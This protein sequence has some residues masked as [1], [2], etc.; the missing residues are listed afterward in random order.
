MPTTSVIPGVTVR[1]VFEPAPVLP[2]ATGILAVVGVTDRGPVDPTPVGSFTE[3]VDTF[4]PASRFTMPELRAAFA[5]G[6][7]RAVVARTAPGRGGKARLTLLDDEGEEVVRLEAR[8]EGA[9]G[10]R[11]RIR[12]VQVRTLSGAGVKYVNLEISV[13]GE[14]VETIENLVMDASSDHYLFDR[15][16]ASSR[17]LVAVDPRMET[18]LPS[19][20][21]STVLDTSGARAAFATLKRG[22]AG[23]ATATAKRRGRGGNRL[24]LRISDGR[25]SLALLD[26]SGGTAAIVRSRAAGAPGTEIRV[27]VEAVNP[28]TVHLIVTP[29]GGA[30]RTTADV[31]SVQELVD[32]LAN[33]PDIVAEGVGNDL[34]VALAATLLRR[35]VDATVFTEGADPRTYDNLAT[36][37]DLA[38]VSDPAVAFAKVGTAT[39]LPD[40]GDG[41]PLSGGRDEGPALTVADDDGDPVVELRALGGVT[42]ALAVQVTHAVSSLDNTTPVATL[43]I[44]ADGQQ[45]EVFSDLTMDPDDERYLPLVLGDSALLR[46]TDLFVPSRTTSTPA[47]VARRTPLAGGASPSADDYQDALDRLETAEEPDLLIASVARQLDDA[48]V[49]EVHQQVVAHCTKMSEVARNRIGIG[50]VTAAEQAAGV[51]AVLDHADD[52][53]SDHFALCTPAGSEGAFAGLLAHL[54]YFDS[55]T[56]K[57]VPALGVEPGHFTDAQLES[58]ISGNVVAIT[59]RRGL[60]I[61]VAK[62]LLTSGR[63]VNVQRTANKAVRDVKAVA[64]VYVG[65]LNDEG[66]R[67]ALKQQVSA[68][69]FQMAADGAL[70]PSTDG[71]SP[72]FTVAVHSTQADFANGI[73]RVDIAIRP[74]R[75]IDYINATI[76]VRN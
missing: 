25:A 17:I 29:V 61:I 28:T 51:K 2:G 23:V 39:E 40:S 63:Q 69:L 27:A 66:S 50:S 1:T 37:D 4:G 15:I 55:P 18:A 62:G 44:A 7:A 59:Q 67:N 32:T 21:G 43:A 76:L 3:F 36:L 72:P 45:T 49:R 75:A 5:N 65:R 14:V 22:T 58:L 34:P 12:V 47:A 56:F 31:T 20:L 35:T 9:W 41:I 68:L 24:A 48:G 38:A 54:D 42:A 10:N 16:N 70:V 73:V 6:V 64:Q 46:A 26:A 71:T 74:V 60:G 52:V 33:D 30:V 8:A 13:E 19:V 11:I 57:T 53:R